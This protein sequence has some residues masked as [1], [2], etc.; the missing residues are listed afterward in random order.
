VRKPSVPKAIVDVVEQAM[1]RDADARYSTAPEMRNALRQAIG[2][3]TADGVPRKEHLS[4]PAKSKVFFS[5]SHK[6]EELRDEL[7]KHL[8]ILKRQGV[9]AGWHD[10]K[11]GV[12]REWADE[13]DKH[14]NTADVILLLI[15]ADFMASD[16]CYD[17]EM[18]RALERHEAGEARVIPVILRPVDWRGAPFGKL[19]ALPTDAQPVTKWSNRDEAFKNVAQGIRVAVKEL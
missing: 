18:K 15:S 6:D 12:G 9:I 2:M 8:S 5:Y 16:Y 10:R 14:L 1:V 13:I 19:Q 3:V 11:I 4:P 7:E 17:I